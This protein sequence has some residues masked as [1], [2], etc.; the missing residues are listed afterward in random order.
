[1]KEQNDQ[2]KKDNIIDLG[3]RMAAQKRM[4]EAHE[5]SMRQM[6]AAQQRR[7]RP[8]PAAG[9]QAPVSGQQLLL[10]RLQEA[11]EL[12]SL[13]SPCTR[14]PYV[15]CDPETFD[16]GVF[17]YF[18]EESAKEDAKRL[19]GEKI[20]VGVVRVEEDKKMNFFSNLFTMGI[21]ALFVKR[22]DGEQE[23]IQLD[24]FIKRR[25]PEDKPGTEWVENPALHLTTL[26]YAQ[27]SRRGPVQD[28]DGKLRDLQEEMLADFR[29]GKYILALEKEK[30]NTPLMKINEELFHPIFTD[31]LEF[32]KFNRD[33]RFL[34]A[35]IPAAVLP[36]HLAQNARGVVINPMGVNMILNLG[37]PGNTAS[38]EG[39]AEASG[40]ANDET[41]NSEKQSDE[42]IIKL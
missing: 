21:N 39:K 2:G 6:E 1:M 4:E 12:F 8:A 38:A 24:Q 18:D 26:Y 16:D 23:L 5:E 42:K 19:I 36:K 10:R 17:L 27:E 31:I 25:M 13:L 34:P 11:K 15:S 29:K 40:Q 28:S 20:P 9:G 7:L 37:R 22:P 14:C 41:V 30:K 35:V 33:G 3:S 32:Q